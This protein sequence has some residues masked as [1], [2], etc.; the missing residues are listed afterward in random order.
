MFVAAQ[1]DLDDRI[2][3]AIAD[4]RQMLGGDELASLLIRHSSTG[5]VERLLVAAERGLIDASPVDGWTWRWTYSPW[6]DVV[7]PVVSARWSAHGNATEFSASW[8]GLAGLVVD[9]PRRLFAEWDE[10][11]P[12]VVD[13]AGRRE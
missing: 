11:F 3:R 6:R 13:R 12:Q 8:P 5:H 7:G 1:P 4:F 2:K 9:R 10:F